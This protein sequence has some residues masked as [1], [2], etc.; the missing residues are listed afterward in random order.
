MIFRSKF[1]LNE[2]DVALLTVN[3]SSSATTVT[4]SDFNCSLGAD[5]MSIECGIKIAST[6][7]KP[8]QKV[9]FLFSKDVAP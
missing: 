9:G 1:L 6:N 5:Q 3:P 2:S 7:E 8:G 4:Y